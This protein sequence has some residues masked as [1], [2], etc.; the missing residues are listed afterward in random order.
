[1]QVW[2]NVELVGAGCGESRKRSLWEEVKN[3]YCVRNGDNSKMACIV[4]LSTAG[5]CEVNKGQSSQL[6]TKDS[7]EL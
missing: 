1:V 5:W 3:Y 4:V 7:R 6:K 2:C